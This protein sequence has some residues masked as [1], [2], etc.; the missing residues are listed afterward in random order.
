MFSHHLHEAGDDVRDSMV[1]DG[2]FE[3]SEDLEGAS[4]IVP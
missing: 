1:V 2:L 4:S 3:G